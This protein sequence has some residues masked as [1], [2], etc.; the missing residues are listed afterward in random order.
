MVQ[1]VSLQKMTYSTDSRCENGYVALDLYP[2]KKGVEFGTIRLEVAPI[3]EKLVVQ[4]RLRWFGHV[5]QTPPET[6][7]YTA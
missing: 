2:Y 3:E 4:H 1:N 7:V 6:L 5:Q